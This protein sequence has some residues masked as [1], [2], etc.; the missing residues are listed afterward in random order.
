ME[1]QVNRSNYSFVDAVVGKDLPDDE[2]RNL[3]KDVVCNVEGTYAMRPGEI[4]CFL[5][6]VKALK[7][8]ANGTTAWGLIL[9]DDALLEDGWLQKLKNVVLELDRNEPSVLFCGHDEPYK[10]YTHPLAMVPHVTPYLTS[11]HEDRAY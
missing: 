3:T 5:S 11:P 10:F 2:R 7:Q 9:E 1:A 6:H 4:G 8:V